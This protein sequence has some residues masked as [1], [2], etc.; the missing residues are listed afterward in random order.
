MS[1]NLGLQIVIGAALAASFRVALGGAQRAVTDLGAVAGRMQTRHEQL[2]AA[3]A[4]AM[5]DP[6][7]PLGQLRQRYDALGRTLEQVRSKTEALNRSIERGAELKAAREER[8]G[9]MQE[10]FGAAVAVAAPVIASVHLATALEDLTNDI[11]ITGDLTR[12]EQQKLGQT[13]RATALRYNQHA[14]DIGAG[15]QVL[16]AAG[17]TSVAEL[18]R[19]AP[20][21][22]ETATATRASVEDLSNVFVVL[23]SNLGLGAQEAGAAFNMLTYAGKR[24]QFEMREMARWMPNLAPMMQGLGVTGK[25]AVAELGAALQIARMGAGS[26]DEAANNLRNFLARITAPETLRNF[27]RAGID[28]KGSLIDLRAQGM[29]P[30]MGTLELIRRYMQQVGGAGALRQFDA[31]TRA[32]DL[33]GIQA[34]TQAYG[35]GNLF[36]DMQVMS[37]IRPALQNMDEFQ[38]I[39]AGALDAAGSDLVSQDFARRMEASSEQMKRFGVLARDIG[40]SIGEALLPPLVSIMETVA[41][42]ARTL[43][44]WAQ[45]HPALIQGV[46]ALGLALTAGKLA[47]LGA[48]WAVSFLILSPLNALRTALLMVGGRWLWLKGLWQIGAFAPALRALSGLGAAFKAVL[49]LAAAFGK[50]L[51]MAVFMPLKLLAQGVWVLARL[52]G[53]ALKGALLAAGKAL[54]WLGRALML[55][56]IGLAVTVIAGGAYLIWRHWDRLGPLFASLWGGIASTL[57]VVWGRIASTVGG[58]WSAL[59]SGF[60]QAWVWLQ[61]LPAQMLSLGTALVDGLA[62]GIRQRIGAAVEAVRSLGQ[63]AVAGLRNLLG[64]RSPS[65]VFAALGAH[66][67]QGLAQGMYASANGVAQAAAGLAAAATFGMSA[68]Q[69]TPLLLPQPA[70]LVQPAPQH[71]PAMQPQLLPLPQPASAAPA[72]AAP[73]PG[74][75]AGMALHYAPVLTIHATSAEPGAVREQ[76][77]QALH[78]SQAEFERYM[79]RY[80]ADAARRAIQ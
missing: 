77:Q 6:L 42:F 33:A 74:A 10:T 15:L 23:R 8:L 22:A 26:S 68:A 27:E 45:A 66:L 24:G 18:E 73:T 46:V 70:P 44:A 54:L 78:L 75:A 53:G 61:G 20:I 5:A 43:A 76:V 7:Q 31:A 56:P 17:V 12:Q 37:F 38:S 80:Q 64:I 69:P 4:R 28:L 65:R 9:A 52:L 49:P 62:Q 3:M 71:L 55:N 1:S 59:R 13:L 72:S 39:R 41:P 30:L 25:E 58:V 79:R 36:Q 50:G 57:S 40:V 19:F 60:A 32:G 35:L 14:T 34:L 63:S 67:G 48:G 16:V 21:L 2:G 29:S 51:W 11:A 47:V